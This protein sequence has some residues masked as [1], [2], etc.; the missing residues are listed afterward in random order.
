M[1]HKVR[2]SNEINVYEHNGKELQFTE[3]PLKVTSHWNREEFVI[4][5]TGTETFTVLADA[6]KVAIENAT[7]VE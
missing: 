4:I 7:N 6:L 2:S 3:K 5:D 1:V